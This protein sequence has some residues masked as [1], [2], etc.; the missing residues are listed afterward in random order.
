MAG[1][2]VGG[3]QPLATGLCAAGGVQAIVGGRAGGAVV[4]RGVVRSRVA[5][6]WYRRVPVVVER[7]RKGRPF[8]GRCQFCAALAVVPWARSTCTSSLP[9][10]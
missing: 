3:I 8:S 9:Y 10:H 6:W 2:S 1:G 7:E 4:E 5:G